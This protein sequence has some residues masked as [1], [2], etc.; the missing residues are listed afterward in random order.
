MPLRA[1][2]S[3]TIRRRAAFAVL[4]DRASGKRFFGRVSSPDARHST[5]TTTEHSYEA[6]RASQVKAVL[7]RVTQLDAATLPSSVA[8]FDTWQNNKAG[9]GAHDASVASGYY[10]T[11]AL[12][13]VNVRYTT[14]DTRP[15]HPGYASGHAATGRHHGQGRDRRCPVRERDEGD[16]HQP[17]QG[18]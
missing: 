2:D 11:A 17:A 9:Y 7:A 8:G 3:A 1:S 5:N 12:T 4:A 13:Q 15:D 6:L 10:D 14:L 16:G 18:G